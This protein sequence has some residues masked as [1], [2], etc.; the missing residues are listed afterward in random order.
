MLHYPPF[1]TTD[2]GRTKPHPKPRSKA[3]LGKKDTASTQ[4]S[5]SGSAAAKRASPEPD[6][7][8]CL[9]RAG[10]GKR[11]ISTVVSAKEVTRFQMVSL[12]VQWY[13]NRWGSLGWCPPFS[14]RELATLY[15]LLYLLFDCTLSL[16]GQKCLNGRQAFCINLGIRSICV[17][18]HAH[19][20]FRLPPP[21][22]P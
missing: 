6:N 5:A 18:A 14:A 17:Q 3:K 20:I 12:N 9:L 11:H 10:N 8:L 21:L 19:F 13:R 22:T 15:S 2:N 7:H 1:T 4:P 16:L